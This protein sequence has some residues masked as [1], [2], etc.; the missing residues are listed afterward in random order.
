MFFIDV[1]DGEENLAVN[2]AEI[3]FA[4]YVGGTLELYFEGGT[5]ESL[6]L[7]GYIAK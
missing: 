5:D 1:S 4:R 6:A 3:K 2:L 7:Q